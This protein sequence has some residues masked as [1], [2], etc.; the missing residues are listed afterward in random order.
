MKLTNDQIDRYR[1][2]INLKKINIQGQIKL[3]KQKVLVIGAGGIGSPVILF[4]SR[5]G[6]LTFGLVD[7]DKINKSN[8]HRQVLFDN[9]DIGKK[10]ILVTKKKIQRIDKKINIKTYNTRVNKSNLKRILKDYDYVID[11]TDNFASKLNINDECVK[12]KKKLFIGSVSQFDAHVFFFD[13]SKDGPC[14]RCFM[15]K[16][17][18]NNTRCQDDGI[19]GTVTGVAGTIISNELIKDAV[20]IPSSLKNQALIINLENLLFRKIKIKESKSCKNYE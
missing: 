18:Q 7:F 19:L 3:K 17:P 9:N 4:L 20:G 8:L 14:L 15:P 11:G 16:E 13:F 1:G 10:K 2:Q 12:Q 5:A 6:V